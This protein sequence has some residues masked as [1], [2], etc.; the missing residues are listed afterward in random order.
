MR[1]VIAAV[2]KLKDG[3]E[4]DLL[5]RYAKRLV[6]SG[7]ALALSPFDMFETPEGRGG[8]VDVRREDEA[9]RLLKL[10]TG[11]DRVIVLDEAGSAMTSP[12]FAMMLGRHRD[13]G[14][15]GVA[16]LIGGPDGH[17]LA[18]KTK[19]TA[20]LSLGSMTLPHG[21]ARIVLVEQLYRAATI[22]S[23]HPYHRT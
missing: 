11:I 8:S 23:G 9:G 12:S 22:L 21:M 16:F 19:A 18:A 14:C 10:V 2:G 20:T 13:A 17:G 3:P 1:L 4:R 7:R 5:D 6:Q 15:S